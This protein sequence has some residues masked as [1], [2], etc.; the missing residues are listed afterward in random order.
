MSGATGLGST[1]GAIAWTWT[2]VSAGRG[3][4]RSGCWGDAGT[5]ALGG[6]IRTTLRTGA[7][8][9]RQGGS[10]V[11]LHAASSKVLARP[12]SAKCPG[13]RARGDCVEAEA[14]WRIV[15]FLSG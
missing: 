5:E 3:S 8:L 4:T 7:G 14:R 11:L 2:M 15:G 13:R 6:G 12:H 10:G 1:G 9:L